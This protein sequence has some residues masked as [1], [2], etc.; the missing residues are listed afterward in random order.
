MTSKEILARFQQIR[1]RHNPDRR[2]PHK[3]LL[4]LWA[5]G[6][7]LGG[8]RRLA[9]FDLI[10]SELT[11]LMMRFGPHNSYLH[12]HYPF[13]RLQNDQ[14]WEI[15]RP[16]LVRTTSSGD[17]H[18]ADLLRHSIQGGFRQHYYDRLQAEPTLAFEIVMSLLHS[19][20][21]ETL[22]QDILEAVGITNALDFLESEPHR[23]RS[24]KLRQGQAAFRESVLDAYER[25]CAV[26][27]LSV[28][29]Q[30]VLIAIEAAH[31]RW[32]TSKGPADV[33][34]GLALCALHHKFFDY[35]AFTVLSDFKVFMSRA[36]EGCGVDE[37]L[38]RYHGH[39]LLVIPDDVE[40]RP[41]DAYLEWHREEVFRT[42]RE[43]SHAVF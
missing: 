32:H 7:C 35:G 38:R 25:Q 5:I 33:E 40:E 27:A 34:N 9:A 4:A 17:A 29:V 43:L 36:A 41:N 16:H 12:T 31:I 20:F 28:R 19:H 8:K 26:C 42:P 14:I 18:R 23:Y 1:I 13:W 6:R 15:D 3:P 11:R 37:T 24:V 30:G 22:H 2:S 39:P 10:D 21:P